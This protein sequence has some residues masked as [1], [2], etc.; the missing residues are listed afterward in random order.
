[1]PCSQ[2]P[3][4]PPPTNQVRVPPLTTYCTSFSPFLINAGCSFCGFSHLVSSY[5]PPRCSYSLNVEGTRRKKYLRGVPGFQISQCTTNQATYALMSYPTWTLYLSWTT[6]HSAELFHLRPAHYWAMLHPSEL[7]WIF[8]ATQHLTEPRGEL[9][10]T[11]N[12]ATPY[13]PSCAATYWA[14]MHP[15]E[16]L[17]TPYGLAHPNWATLHPTELHCILLSYAVPYWATVYLAELHCI[18]LSYPELCELRCTLNELH[19]VYSIFVQFFASGM[20][21][22]PVPE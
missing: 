22:Y 2:T 17:C 3:P 15:A 18:L 20:A 5:F 21:D 12:W 16:L 6:L 14:T 7:Q 4:P 11:Y 1:M 19:T 10:C 8:L 9:R 13:L